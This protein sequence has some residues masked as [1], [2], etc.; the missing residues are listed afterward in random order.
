MDRDSSEKIEALDE[1]GKTILYVIKENEKGND[2]IKAWGLLDT[3]LEQNILKN[4]KGNILLS[5][6]EDLLF[7]IFKWKGISFGEHSF[8]DIDS[9]LNDLML[10]QKI[11]EKNK[12]F[13]SI[14]DELNVPSNNINSIRKYVLWKYKDIA[15][16]YLGLQIIKNIQEGKIDTDELLEIAKG[17]GFKV[18]DE[19]I[20]DIINVIKEKYQKS[21]Q[22]GRTIEGVSK[23]SD[24]FGVKSRLIEQQIKNLKDRLQ[25]MKSRYVDKYC[26]PPKFTVM[27]SK[28]VEGK[29]YFLFRCIHLGMEILVHSLLDG[30]NVENVIIEYK[31]MIK[32]SKKGIKIDINELKEIMKSPD[33]VRSFTQRLKSYNS[34]LQLANFQEVIWF[35]GNFATE[36]NKIPKKTAEYIRDNFRNYVEMLDNSLFEYTLQKS[37]KR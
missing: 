8:D 3:E 26:K 18:A 31:R 27:E 19:E 35:T 21:S 37:I 15:T 11:R 6:Y 7:R 1:I 5:E 14:I 33:G 24:E 20:K 2:I 4:F 32:G 30:T 13:E 23:E 25:K 16:D 17:D 10:K 36:Q 29:R 22:K 12:I 28:E 9:L 34:I